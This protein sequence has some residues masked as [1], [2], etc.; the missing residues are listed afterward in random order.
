MGAMAGA[1]GLYIPFVDGGIS[2]VPTVGFLDLKGDWTVEGCGVAPNVPVEEDPARM[3]SA[4]DSQLDAAIGILLDDLRKPT[5]VPTE[6]PFNHPQDQNQF[7]SFS[8][9]LQRHRGKCCHV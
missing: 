9:S 8:I 5:P 6:M 2:L 1:G 3:W 7:H 4:D